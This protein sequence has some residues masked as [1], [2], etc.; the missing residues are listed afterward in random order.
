MNHSA[1]LVVTLLG[2]KATGWGLYSSPPSGL[3]TPAKHVAHAEL[4]QVSASSYAEARAQ[5]LACLIGPTG[6][7]PQLVA[8]WGLPR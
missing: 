5:L 3:T 1:H 8:V 7:Y 6:R 4:M 2:T